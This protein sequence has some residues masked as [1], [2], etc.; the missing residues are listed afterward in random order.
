MRTQR[1]IKFFG[2]FCVGLILGTLCASE[3]VAQDYRAKVQGVVTDSTRAAVPGATVT[4][5]NDNTGVETVRTSNESGHY[6]FDFVEPGTYTVTVE[7]PGFSKFT[8]TNIQVQVRGDV[9]V[10][11]SLTVGRRGGNGECAGIDRHPSV[12][13]QHHGTDC[14]SQNAHGPADPGEESVYPRAAQPGS[15]QSLPRHAGTRFLCGHR[16]AST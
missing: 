6:I 12:Q 13:Y 10:N 11:A 15:R 7:H 4:L 1:Q 2:T 8:Q 5:S 14:R 9:T 16:A 3:L